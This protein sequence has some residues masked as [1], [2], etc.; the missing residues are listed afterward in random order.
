MRE[1]TRIVANGCFDLLHDGHVEFLM[2]ARN[3]GYLIVAINSDESARRLKAAKWGA[4][5]PRDS[6]EVRADNLCKL[7]V[8]QVIIFNTE[9]DLH[10]IIEFA[11]PCIIVKGPDYAGREKE[12]TGSDIAPV[13]I[14]DTPE[15]P[16]IRELKRKAYML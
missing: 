5:Y 2:M 4:A 12:V 16:Q 6:Q 9:E 1:M 13:L 14:L 7:G 15:T 3:L 11:S 10:T 8:A